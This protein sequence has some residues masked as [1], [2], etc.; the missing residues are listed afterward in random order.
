M[1]VQIVATQ[2]LQTPS[3]PVPLRQEWTQAGWREARTGISV[4]VPVTEILM[5]LSYPLAQQGHASG[6]WVPSG[7]SPD[8]TPM[9][10]HL[11]SST[12][13]RLAAANPFRKHPKQGPRWGVHACRHMCASMNPLNTPCCIGPTPRA[14][15]RTQCCPPGC[16][17]SNRSTTRPSHP[18]GP[19]VLTAMTSLRS[20]RRRA[21]APPFST[22]YNICRITG[23]QPI[24]V[25]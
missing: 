22:R 17:C 16:S 15:L 13:I 12:H 19:T 14:S 1:S 25:K 10:P 3:A 6:P 20:M 9:D 18:L 24:G 2:G 7:L 5:P 4:E 23:T 21:V 11:P 8:A